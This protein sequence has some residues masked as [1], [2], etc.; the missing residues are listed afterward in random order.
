MFLNYL[1]TEKV[2]GIP[3]VFIAQKMLWLAD[4]FKIEDLQ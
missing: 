1:E 2:E 4:F 3:D